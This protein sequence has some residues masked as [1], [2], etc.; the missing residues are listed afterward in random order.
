M[1]KTVKDRL[2]EEIGRLPGH[3]LQEVLDF[4]GYLVGKERP[5][6][7]EALEGDPILGVVGCL[8]GKPLAP[9]EIEEELYGEGATR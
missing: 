5:R 2:L 8:S 1:D 6:T 3:R 4:V 9:A 7:G